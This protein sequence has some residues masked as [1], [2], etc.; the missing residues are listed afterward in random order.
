MNFPAGHIQNNQ[1]L[2]MGGKVSMEVGEK[3]IVE[4][5]VG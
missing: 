5:L 4:I 3:S 2:L 1:P